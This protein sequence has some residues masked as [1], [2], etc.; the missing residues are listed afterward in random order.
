M[1]DSHAHLNH[2]LLVNE[3][4]DVVSRFVESG[5]KYILN[6]GIDIESSLLALEQHRAREIVLPAVALHPELII[7]GTEVNVSTISEKW[8]DKNSEEIRKIVEKNRKE[9]VAIGECGLDYFWVKRER[10]DNREENYKYQRLLFSKM[11]ELAVEFDMPLILHCRD[12][13]GDKQAAAEML[14]ILVRYGGSKLR[15]VFHSFTGPISYLQDI[16]ALGYYVGVN[17]IVTYKGADN[18]REILD[19]VPNDRLLLETDAP[20]LVPQKLRSAGIKVAEP[21]FVQEVAEYVAKRKGMPI[22]VLWKQVESNFDRFL[23]FSL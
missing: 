12:E 21:V 10:L 19:A 2:A 18:V 20:Y 15:A 4:D 13:Q 1:I 6:N 8:I 16:L 14:E 9:I 3:F 5:G 22:S 7:P 17:G 11:V 23:G